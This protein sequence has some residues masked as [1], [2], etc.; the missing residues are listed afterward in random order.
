[1]TH[2][3]I[4]SHPITDISTNE[5]TFRLLLNGINLIDLA[6]PMSMADLFRGDVQSKY[7]FRP[8]VFFSS[9][10]PLFSRFCRRGFSMTT[11]RLFTLLSAL[12]V[13]V[14]L[15]LLSM[16]TLLIV[17]LSLVRS[18]CPYAP[19]L[20]SQRDSPEHGH[21]A[22]AGWTAPTDAYS[23]MNLTAPRRQSK[24]ASPTAAPA[25]SRSQGSSTVYNAVSNVAGY[26]CSSRVAHQ[27]GFPVCGDYLI[28]GAVQAPDSD[29]DMAC[30]GDAT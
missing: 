11:F 21:T 1:M 29:C 10:Q 9:V 24:V 20:L 12:V 17:S 18:R 15:W 4:Q 30:G 25:V 27:V 3:P 23:E 26:P 7:L 2:L 28:N 5:G 16:P 22:D 6:P 8:H 14:S 13:Y 19:C